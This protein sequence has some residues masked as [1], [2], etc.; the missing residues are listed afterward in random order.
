MR[1]EVVTW[2]VSY[3]RQ[4]SALPSP[5]DRERSARTISSV[6]DKHH[7]LIIRTRS[8]QDIPCTTTTTLLLPPLTTTTNPFEV[9]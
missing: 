7:R 1:V 2:Q 5:S 4:P 9:I 3:I 8:D 6:K